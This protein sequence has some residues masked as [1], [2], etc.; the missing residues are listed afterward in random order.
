[1]F[2]PSFCR[3]VIGFPSKPPGIIQGQKISSF[4]LEG[5]RTMPKS[6]AANQE[7]LR[8]RAMEDARVEFNSFEPSLTKFSPSPSCGG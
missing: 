8:E 7:T 1:M 6:V 4:S 5:R 2:Q 3:C